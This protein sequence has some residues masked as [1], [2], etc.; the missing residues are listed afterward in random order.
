MQSVKIY[1]SIDDDIREK[2]SYNERWGDFERGLIT[3]WE[4]GFGY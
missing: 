3:S 4:S 2:T 1:K